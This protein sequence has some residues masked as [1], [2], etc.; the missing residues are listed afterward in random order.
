MRVTRVLVYVLV[1]AVVAFVVVGAVSVLSARPEL[2]DA[3]QHVNRTWS[4]LATELGPR[5]AQLA[6]A[7]DELLTLTGPVRT[8]ADHVHSAVND[9]N[10]AK[11]H[12]SVAAQVR[13]ANNLEA[14]SRRLVVAAR[15]SERVKAD[16]QMTSAVDTFA[17]D[18]TF[19]AAGGITTVAAFNQA[20]KDYEKERNGPVRG[21]VATVLNA[22]N[23]PAFA[24]APF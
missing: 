13:A 4:P 5:Y 18:P 12:G 9:W 23:I 2:N 1:V 3:K 11:A 16:P 15:A 20:V 8:L 6:Q 24:P 21:V 7:D 17:G 10:N 19:S 14:L 22:P